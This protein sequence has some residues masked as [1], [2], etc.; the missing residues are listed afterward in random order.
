[1]PCWLTLKPMPPKTPGKL[2]APPVQAKFDAL[3]LPKRCVPGYGVYYRLHGVDPATK[4]PW[5]PVYFGKDARS[6]FDP[7]AGPGTFYVAETLAGALLEKFD[8][9]WGPA[10]DMTRSLTQSQLDQWWVS[11]IAIPPFTVFEARKYLSMIG[12]DMQLLSGDHVQAREWALVLARH[13]AAIDGICYTSRHDGTRFNLAMFEKAGRPKEL[14]D[15]SLSPPA[16]IHGSRVIPTGS[17]IYYGPPVLLGK[18]PELTV[19]LAEL[20]VALLP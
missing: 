11:L 9:S 17:P 1:M 15:N 10:G 4:K 19:T 13:P 6:R 12:T 8:D 3:P 2:N 20:D 7:A 18:H 5:V 16:A 14:L